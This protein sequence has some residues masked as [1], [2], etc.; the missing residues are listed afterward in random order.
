MLDQCSGQMILLKRGT[1]MG[2]SGNINL[3]HFEWDT[4]GHP[5]YA[6]SGHA[7]DTVLIFKLFLSSSKYLLMFNLVCPN[8][9]CGFM[10]THCKDGN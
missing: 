5:W 6:D 9:F 4:G 1:K 7:L 2:F 3:F 10:M 8:V